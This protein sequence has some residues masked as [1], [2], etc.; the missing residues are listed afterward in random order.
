MNQQ[1]TTPISCAIAA[2]LLSAIPCFVSGQSA[3]TPEE[4]LRQWANEAAPVDAGPAPTSSQ[5]KTRGL[6][7]SYG[8][9]QPQTTTTYEKRTVVRKTTKLNQEHI[10]D[11]Q[12]NPQYNT[13][14]L[15]VQYGSDNAAY[16]GVE[17]D[18]SSGVT[19]SNILFQKNSTELAD[20]A[21]F[22]QILAIAEAIRQ[23]PG[24]Q[25]LVEG[26]TCD[27]GSDYHNKRL[28]EWRADAIRYLLLQYGVKE[29]QIITLGFGE[30][31]PAFPNNGEYNRRM[32]RRVV[33]YK[34]K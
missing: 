16:V 20:Q 18:A 26:H 33:I 34:R 4:L 14:G 13:R 29:W 17:V 31:E 2:L 12:S 6:T 1:P 3:K 7:R 30:M 28:S 9:P 10:R 22:Q 8:A 24:A 23:L 32:N 27:L 11:Y 15:S 19:F 5:P 21:S 25:F